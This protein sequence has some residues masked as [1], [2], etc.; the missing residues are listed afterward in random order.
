[1]NFDCTLT[2]L[3]Q[4]VNYISVGRRAYTGLGKI[5]DE[6]NLFSS[7]ML[8]FL[9]SFNNNLTICSYV[10]EDKMTKY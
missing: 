1:M 8:S 10:F 2:S 5:C 7:K 4:M 6:V 9:L 3:K